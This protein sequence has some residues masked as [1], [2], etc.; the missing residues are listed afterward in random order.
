MNIKAIHNLLDK[1]EKRIV[2]LEKA[3]LNFKIKKEM[4]ICPHCKKQMVLAMICPRSE[5]IQA[6]EH[7]GLICRI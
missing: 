6:I 5:I 3:A 1:H 2:E 7:I 4:L